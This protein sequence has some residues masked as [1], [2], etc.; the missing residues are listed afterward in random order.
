[1]IDDT[2]IEKLADVI[3]E[4]L[5]A[6]EPSTMKFEDACR[7]LFHG[8]SREWVK[9]YIMGQHPEVLTDHGGWITPPKHKGVRIKVIDVKAAKKWLAENEHKLDWTAPEPITLKRRAGL[10]KPIKRN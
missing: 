3:A 9:Y 7:E 4:R 8:K 10:A 1:M 5:K 6:K 2:T